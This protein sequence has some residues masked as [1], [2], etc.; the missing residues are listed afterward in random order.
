MFPEKLIRGIPNKDFITEGRLVL[1]SLFHFQEVVEKARLNP[2]ERTDNNYEESINWYDD[3]EALNS[4][5][6]QT[7]EDGSLKYKEGAAILSKNAIDAVKILPVA[8]NRLTYERRSVDGNIYHGNLLLSRDTS[9]HAMRMIAS[10]IA[11]C[12]EVTRNLPRSA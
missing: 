8:Y 11:C 2:S 1:P 3:E 10:A 4:L 7:K 5:L 9:K 12:V 6:R